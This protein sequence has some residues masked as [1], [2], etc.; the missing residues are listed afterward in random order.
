MELSKTSL[1]EKL[2]NYGFISHKHCHLANE[3][4][5]KLTFIMSCSTINNI[6]R[7]ASPHTT[8]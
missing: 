8:D 6:R 5:N 7:T 2:L 4:M 3:F 1:F